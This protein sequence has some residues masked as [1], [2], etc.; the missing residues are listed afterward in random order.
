MY[1]E[2]ANADDVSLTESSHRVKEFSI[3]KLSGDYRTVI[4]R[5]T[6]FEHE[7]V[8]YDDEYEQL[9]LSDLD[10]LHREKAQTEDP[11]A[12]EDSSTTNACGKRKM[13]TGK[14][15][16]KKRTKTEDKAERLALRLSF[17][18]PTSSYATMVIRQLTKYSTAVLD[19][20]K[21]TNR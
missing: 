14:E 18:L 13:E 7:I 1:H 8:P 4:G 20:V 3:E 2:I 10:V 17:R 15:S 19:Q 16:E 6:H 5:A 9:I 21:I 11:D 12:L